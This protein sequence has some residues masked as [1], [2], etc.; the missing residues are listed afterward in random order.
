MY[1]TDSLTWGSW[2]SWLKEDSF[3]SFYEHGVDTPRQEPRDVFGTEQVSDVL[4]VAG[5]ERMNWLGWFSEWV[6]IRN[7]TGLTTNGASEQGR[8]VYING[9]RTRPDERHFEATNGDDSE[10]ED[11]IRVVKSP[12]VQ[13]TMHQQCIKDVSLKTGVG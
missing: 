9:A 10:I 12:K 8:D 2:G 3:P 4:V 11:R 6:R 13:R 7:G 5:T 1:Q